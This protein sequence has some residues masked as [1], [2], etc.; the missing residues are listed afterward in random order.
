MGK[1]YINEKGNFVHETTEAD[2]FRLLPLED[3]IKIVAIKFLKKY[4]KTI[5]IVLGCSLLF[6]WFQ[7][8][9]SEIRKECFILLK[10]KH[11][12]FEEQFKYF[13]PEYKGC[14]LQKGLD[15]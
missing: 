4:Y 8:R 2:L 10:N 13:E 3:K 7:Y 1:S 11:Y 6:Y 5:F 12:D 15:S 14:L 9:P